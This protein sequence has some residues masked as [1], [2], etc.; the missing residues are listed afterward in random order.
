[1]SKKEILKKLQNVLNDPGSTVSGEYL[2][3][4]IVMQLKRFIDDD[5]VGVVQALLSW[6]ELRKE[7]QTMIAVRMAA[8]FE[9]KELRP[10]IE[11]LAQEIEEGNIFLPFY[12]RWTDEALKKLA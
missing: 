12:K 8:E 9:L 1:M 10:V 4:H 2:E 11:K 3:R 5:Y 6:L 7:P